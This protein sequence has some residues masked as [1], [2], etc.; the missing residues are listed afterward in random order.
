VSTNGALRLSEVRAAAAA[1]LAPAT[2]T[3]PTVLV[4][5][6]DA[7]HPPALMLLW[8]DPFLE[9]QVVGMGATGL[10]DARFEVLAVASR[11]EPGPGMTK[12]EELV[13]F[14]M[15]RLAADPYTWPADTLYAPRRFDIGGVTYLGARLVFKVPV[16]L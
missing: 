4:D 12:I 16:T 3:D 5:I 6:V 1:A 11:V 7:L 10:W 8:T 9:P 15:N 14:V 2:D 13:A